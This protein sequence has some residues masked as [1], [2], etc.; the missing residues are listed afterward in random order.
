MF[1]RQN[2]ESKC[3]KMQSKAQAFIRLCKKHFISV[4]IT[5]QFARVNIVFANILG[6]PPL[7]FVYLQRKAP[8][9]VYP[10]LSIL[11]GINVMWDV[12]VLMCKYIW[13]KC[14][15]DITTRVSQ[16]L[17]YICPHTERYNIASCSS[18]TA[19]ATFE[20]TYTHWS[21]A[22]LN[23]TCTNSTPFFPLPFST[24]LPDNY[25]VHKYREYSL[26]GWSTRK[27]KKTL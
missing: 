1:I 23:Q 13:D 3:R 7:V 2:I 24:I 17:S 10:K 22:L 4:K 9:L 12:Q 8:T 18:L 26:S 25:C 11:L 20:T 15:I 19:P 5:V 16:C 6:L 14:F 21:F 27:G